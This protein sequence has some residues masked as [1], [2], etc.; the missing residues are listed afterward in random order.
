M[1]KN[2]PAN[3][4]DVGHWGLIPGSGR[5]PEGGNGNLCQ[6]ACREK[7]VDRGVWWAPVHGISKNRT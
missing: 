5:F 1:V 4:R 3:V 7:S 6:Y 2:L